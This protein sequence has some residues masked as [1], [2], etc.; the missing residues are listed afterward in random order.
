TT[1]K[2][3]VKNY[4]VYWFRKAHEHLG[5]GQRAGLVGTNSIW[6][7]RARGASLEYIAANGGV[8]T[9]AV[10]PPGI[11]ILDGEPVEGITPELRTPG[12][13]TGVVARLKANRGRCFQGPIPAGAGFIIL[14]AEA[15][16][17]LGRT[18][19]NYNQVVRPY[20][21]GDDIAEDP[22]QEP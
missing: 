7:N 17:L 15:Q 22:R 4:C 20:L 3:G 5:T 1:F 19:A 13:S 16:Q 2:I 18:D 11:F 8:I 12:H 21:T 9:D 14:P 10:S 6:Q